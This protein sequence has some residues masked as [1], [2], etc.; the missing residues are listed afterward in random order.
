MDAALSRTYVEHHFQMITHVIIIVVGIWLIDR[1]STGISIVIVLIDRFDWRSLI[2]VGL[3][4]GIVVSVVIVIVVWAFWRWFPILEM[5]AILLVKLTG[6]IIIISALLILV[7]IFGDWRSIGG[8]RKLSSFKIEI[9]GRFASW[10]MVSIRRLESVLS[11]VLK[12]FVGFFVFLCL[13]S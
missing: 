6:I 8:E 4:S 12:R 13:G 11:I 7:A 10:I 3:T 5:L 1:R 9:R 2:Q